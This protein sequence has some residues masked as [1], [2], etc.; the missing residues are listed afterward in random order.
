MCPL[1]AWGV[2]P[3]KVPA[4]LS[5]E[6]ALFLSDIFPTGSMAADFCNIQQGDTIKVPERLAMAKAQQYSV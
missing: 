5:D 3:I 1:L 2:G 4:G 6:Q